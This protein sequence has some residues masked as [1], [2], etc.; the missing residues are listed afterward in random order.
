MHIGRGTTF[1]LSHWWACVS[2]HGSGEQPE[3][4][5]LCQENIPSTVCISCPHSYSTIPNTKNRQP[6]RTTHNGSCISL[7]KP[8]REAKIWLHSG[9]SIRG[10]A[11]WRSRVISFTAVLDQ[12]IWTPPVHFGTHGPRHILLPTA[13]LVTVHCGLVI[14]S[15]GGTSI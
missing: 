4:A 6:F 14:C 12:V 3:I 9:S 11:N 8:F 1:E 15:V 2:S 10:P 13:L 7:S 5:K